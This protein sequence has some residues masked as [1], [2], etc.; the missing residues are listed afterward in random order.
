[1][2]LTKPEFIVDN[3]NINIVVKV[4]SVHLEATPGINE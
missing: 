2:M 4:K 1:M 3:N